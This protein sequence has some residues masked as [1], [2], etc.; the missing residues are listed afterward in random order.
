MELG[1]TLAISASG[2]DVQSARLRVIAQNLANEDSTGTTPGAD[3]YRRRTISF[4]DRMDRTLGVQTVRVGRIGEDMSAFP[5]RYDPSNPAADARG[6]VKLP[7]VNPF[8]ELM[9]MHEA[10][11][12][13]TANLNVLQV[14][15]SMLTRAIG[16]LK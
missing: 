14:T 4:Q 3:P 7:N 11:R 10:Q 1:K 9:D 2:M 16:L 13:F 6:Y 12:S 5:T 15:R 8:T